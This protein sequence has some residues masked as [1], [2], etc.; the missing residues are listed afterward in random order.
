MTLESEINEAKQQTA[1]KVSQEILQTMGQATQMLKDQGIE[2]NAL[3]K[4]DKAVDFT[5]PNVHGE[6]V[7][8]QQQLEKGPVVLSVYRGGWCPYCNLELNALKQVVPE[9]E[10]LGAQLIAMAPQLPDRSMDT[11][12][13]HQLEFEV[14]SDV[15]N[16]VSRQYGLVFTLPESLRPIY[17]QFNLDIAG[18]NGDDTFELPMPATY[19]IAQNGE[20]VHA[21]VDAD[22]TARMEPSEIIEVLSNLNR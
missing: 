20:I 21:F 1:A 10:A 7:N 14:L 8:L 13:K 4:G 16:V 22:Y 18:Y 9:I 19:V 6:D 2:N 17:A 11:A 3:G 12:Q 15:G 5:L